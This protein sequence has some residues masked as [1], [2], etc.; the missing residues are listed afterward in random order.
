MNTSNNARW[1]DD[2]V[3]LIDGYR[4][5]NWLAKGAYKQL[6][7]ELTKLGVTLNLEKT[8]HIDLMKDEIFNF[9]GFVFRRTKTKRGKWGITKI[10]KME[11]RT[12]LLR[13]L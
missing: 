3:I 1:A 2:L 4:K 8:Q 12:K 11:A 9:L 6:C 13:K 10:P 7:E 5:W